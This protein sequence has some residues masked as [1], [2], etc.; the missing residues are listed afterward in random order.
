MGSSVVHL[1]RSPN[2]S[3]RYL[4]LKMSEVLSGSVVSEETASRG[5][6]LFADAVFKAALFSCA[7]MHSLRE[8]AGSPLSFKNLIA[9]GYSL[10]NFW[11]VS[12]DL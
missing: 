1:V 3:C 10:A 2:T 8:A 9:F 12:V 11:S 7:S 6:Y 4:L 5:A